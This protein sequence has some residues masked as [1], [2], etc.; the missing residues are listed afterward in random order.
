MSTDAV[1]RPL[2]EAD[3]PAASAICRQAFATFLRAPDPDTFWA[4]REYVRTRWHADPSAALAADV[5]GSLAGS[6][7]LTRW[8]S[9]GFFGP[10]TVQPQ[11]SNRGIAQH[12][13]GATI[14]MLDAWQV[15]D[16]GLFTFAD[17]P[18][19]IHLYQKFGFWPRF[20]TAVLSK[21]PDERAAAPF[22]RYSQASE[23][24]RSA[25]VDACRELTTLIYDGLDV[26]REIRSVYSQRLG[27]TVLLAGGD[28][29]DAFAVCHL[30]EGTEAG[31]QTCYLKFA[32]TRPGRD[33]EEVFEQ[34]LDACEALARQQGLQRMEA[35]VNLN[36][37]RVYRSML[38]RGFRADSYGISMHRPDSPAYNRPDV[39]IVDD[40]R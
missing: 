25:V 31:A 13:M 7:L 14:D 20:L 39:Y 1:I 17:S 8:G 4:D 22:T 3:L 29:L 40:L 23:S 36:R 37:R 35:G 38:R 33:A 2:R 19:H 6:N 32:A 15:S 18:R 26:E 34:M 27:E 5:D 24:E 10:L 21:S 28:S 12:L 16:A 11:L 9:F 30:G